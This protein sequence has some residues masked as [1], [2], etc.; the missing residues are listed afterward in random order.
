MR[1]WECR[2][3]PFRQIRRQGTVYQSRVVSGKQCDK[4]L[5]ACMA[6]LAQMS[7]FRGSPATSFGGSFSRHRFPL[8][9]TADRAHHLM[10][11]L[12]HGDVLCGYPRRRPCHRSPCVMLS[13]TACAPLAPLSPIDDVRV[14]SPSLQPHPRHPLVERK[15]DRHQA[16]IAFQRNN[17]ILHTR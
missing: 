3:R 11:L 17:R 1:P 16:P 9:G 12:A 2:N 4:K 6:G 7:A 8:S 10:L 15:H 14:H 5:V 13:S